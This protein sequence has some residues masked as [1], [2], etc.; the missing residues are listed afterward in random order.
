[1]VAGFADICDKDMR[2]FVVKVQFMGVKDVQSGNDRRR[3]EDESHLIFQVYQT[4]VVWAV[5]VLGYQ[6]I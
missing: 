2:S 5:V 6:C 3:T 1:M 4:L